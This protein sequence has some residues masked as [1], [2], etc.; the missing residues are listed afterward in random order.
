MHCNSYSS[1]EDRHPEWTLHDG[2]SRNFGMSRSAKYC[3]SGCEIHTLHMHGF[4]KQWTVNIW[5]LSWQCHVNNLWTLLQWAYNV[6]WTLT[7]T[8]F[9]KQWTVNIWTLSWQCHVNNLWTL[10]QWA[11]NVLWTLTWTEFMKQWTV[12]IAAMLYM[13]FLIVPFMTGWCQLI[14]V[15]LHYFC[16]LG[17]LRHI[18]YLAH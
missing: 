18:L 2:F 3:I 8:E 15:L 7:W 13:V 12:N 10:L 4:T 5:T 16:V 9:M 14:L 17:L 1:Q 11:Y 6:L